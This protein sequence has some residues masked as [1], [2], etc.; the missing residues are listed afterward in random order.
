[1]LVT[2]N[3]FRN[4]VSFRTFKVLQQP[5]EVGPLVTPPPLFWMRKLN[6]REVYLRK[7][8]NWGA[9]GLNWGGNQRVCLQS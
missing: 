8:G 6:F 4:L 5:C 7:V 2:A 9:T 1:M 3:I